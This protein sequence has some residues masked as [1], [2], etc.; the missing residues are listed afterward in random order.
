MTSLGAP[1]ADDPARSPDPPR[2][3]TLGAALSTP[4]NA[5]NA[6]RL[7]LALLVIVSHTPAVTG[8]TSWPSWVEALGGWAVLGFF[9]ISG[10]LIVGSRLRSSWWSYAIRRLARIF[11]AY[12]A[13]LLFVGLAAAP[14]AAA[15]GFGQWDPAV[16]LG[17]I[18]D[19]A[20]TFGLSWTMDGIAMPHYDAW[21]GSA[22]TLSYELLAY[23]GCLVLF[24]VPGTRRR[25]TATCA[26]VLLGLLAFNL[27]VVPAADVTTNLYLHLGRL[28]SYFV[29]GM[30]LH[31]LRDRLP[32]RGWAAAAG[33]ALAL[34]LLT[35][36]WGGHVAQLPLAYGL[37]GLGGVLPLRLGVSNDLSYGTYL[38]AFP[39]QQLVTMAHPEVDRPLLHV[40]VSTALTLL[41]AAASWRL[42]ERPAMTAARAAIGLVRGSVRASEPG[43]PAR[44]G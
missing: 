41:A 26:V 24:W 44:L 43:V 13:Q 33:L 3:R 18:A 16:A 25:P 14:A 30:L 38:F 35:T 37:L 17:Y 31:C 32:L 6:L 21:N 34:A 9:T 8:T 7:L 29:G 36:D 2:G 23:L 12:W 42:V 39:V 5:L 27:V 28:G 4:A 19:N 15:W 20:T 11:P 1:L 10:Y 22:W 40:L